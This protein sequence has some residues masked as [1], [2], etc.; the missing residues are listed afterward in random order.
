LP[1]VDQPS[2]SWIVDQAIL[3]R[4]QSETLSVATIRAL[5]PLPL[6][7]SFDPEIWWERLIL[8]QIGLSMSGQEVVVPHLLHK[9]LNVVN[10]PLRGFVRISDNRSYCLETR[11]YHPC[12]LLIPFSLNVGQFDPACPRDIFVFAPSTANVSWI[13]PKLA[14]HDLTWLPLQGS[15]APGS[16]FSR[17]TTQVAYTLPHDPSQLESTRISCTFNVCDVVH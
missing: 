2:Y 4:N 12:V 16:S 13:E 3:P 10:F 6:T 9:N 15:V 14:M 7:Y 17:G 8:I 5:S 11:A 1:F